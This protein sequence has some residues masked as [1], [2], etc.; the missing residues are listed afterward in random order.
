MG[1]YALFS[2]FQKGSL[3]KFIFPSFVPN[4]FFRTDIALLRLSRASSTLIL[5]SVLVF[6]TEPSSCEIPLSKLIFQ[7]FSPN[8]FLRVL[9]FPNSILL[10]Y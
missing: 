7:F 6:F 4:I 1:Y 2:S 5:K 10:S 3:S 8:I 9:Y